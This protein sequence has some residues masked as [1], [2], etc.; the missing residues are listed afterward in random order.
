MTGAEK[1]NEV[2]GMTTIREAAKILNVSISRVHQFLRDGRLQ[3]EKLTPNL[4][5]VD[6]NDVKRLAKI[7]RKTGGAGHRRNSQKAG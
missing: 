4:Y 1:S 6:V 3:G 7:P 2:K 5:V